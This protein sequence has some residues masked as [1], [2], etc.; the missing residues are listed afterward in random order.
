MNL[1]EWDYNGDGLFEEALNN[2]NQISLVYDKAGTYYI[3]LRVTD[4]EGQIGSVLEEITVLDK[5]F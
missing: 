3:G 4:D 2:V 1:I 5:V